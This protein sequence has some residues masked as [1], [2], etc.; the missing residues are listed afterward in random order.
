[1]RWALSDRGG[2]ED[3]GIDDYSHR[4]PSAS[5]PASSNGFELF[6]GERY[7]V[8]F[9]EIG[10]CCSYRSEVFAATFREVLPSG[11][12]AHSECVA[13]LVPAR[14]CVAGGCDLLVAYVVEF[15]F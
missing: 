9:G 5:A 10:I 15:G 2:D 4:M 12:A 14:T 1:M 13:D 3:V 7:G 8:L 6:D 11:L